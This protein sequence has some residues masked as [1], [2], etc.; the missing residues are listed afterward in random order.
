MKARAVPKEYLGKA[1]KV[2][3]EVCGTVAGPR[4]KVEVRL[5]EPG[6]VVPLVRRCL[7]SYVWCI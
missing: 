5:E 3:T 4:G 6:P 1:R 2:D 7:V